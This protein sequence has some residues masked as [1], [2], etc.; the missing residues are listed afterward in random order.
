MTTRRTV[1]CALCK[2]I[3]PYPLQGVTFEFAPNRR[4]KTD[5][6]TTICP[7]CYRTITG[8]YD[9]PARL[10]ATTTHQTHDPDGDRHA[11]WTPF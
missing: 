4:G 7:A 8:L 6:L 5:V 9:T 11:F 3:I 1:M 2:E 10:F